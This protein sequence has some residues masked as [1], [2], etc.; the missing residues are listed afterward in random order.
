MFSSF[1]VS[2]PRRIASMSSLYPYSSMNGQ[3]SSPYISRSSF[4][5]RVTTSSS[6][7]RFRIASSAASI[8]VDLCLGLP[9]GA[10]AVSF[11]H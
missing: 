2:E 3:P 6:K 8:L 5:V 11:D 1:V 10:I 4:T 7:P 9:R